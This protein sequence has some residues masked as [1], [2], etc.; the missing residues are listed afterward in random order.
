MTRWS[1]AAALLL[2]TPACSDDVGEGS[3]SGGAPTTEDGALLEVD[4]PASGRVFLRLATPEIVAPADEGAASTD[5][6][7]ALSGYDVF[8]NS[9]LSGPGDGGALPLSLDDYRAGQLPSTPF[10]LTDE[11]GGAFT[12]WYAYDGESHVAFSR[13]H[14]HAIEHEGRTW[15]LQIL[16]FYGEVDGAP[17]TALYQLRVAEVLPDGPGETVEIKDLDATAGGIDAV[18]SAPSA[19]LDLA[20][21]RQ[22]MLTPAEARASTEWHVCF[23][24]SLVTVNGE[25]GGPGTA[26]GADLQEQETRSEALADVKERTAESERAR[27]DAADHQA[28]TDP[29]V[30]YR[31]DHVATAFTGRWIE[32]GSSPPAP[33]KDSAWLV[34]SADGQSRFVA[35]FERFEG[36]TDASPG[37]VIMRVK[38]VE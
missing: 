33:A 36:A 19:C 27:F 4:V 16:S 32:P 9:G 6:D 28:L 29:A 3:S 7:L 31:G 17:V 10:L 22:L 11:A 21:N 20:G 23:R 5:W 24:R 15:K 18:E 13:Y 37:R 25:L 1:I 26:R 12:Q 14:V 30:R 38:Q 8:T 34:Q 35:L 2:L